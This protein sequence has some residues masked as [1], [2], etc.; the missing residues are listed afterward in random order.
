MLQPERVR[1]PL[2][3]APLRAQHTQYTAHM[4]HTHGISDDVWAHTLHIHDAA[5]AAGT[6]TNYELAVAHFTEW[7]CAE[8]LR[9]DTDTAITE[10][11]LCA[12]AASL[13]GSYSGGTARTKLAG[14]RYWH[15]KR[16]LPWNG[17]ARLKRIL[18]GV[19]ICA[20]P[21]THR[22][23]RPPVTEAMID[24]ALQHLDPIRPFDVCVAAAML[25]AFW[26]QLRLG[27]ILSPTRAYDFGARPAGKGVRLRADA[28]GKLHQL[29]SAIWLPRTKVDRHGAWIWLARHHNDPSYALAEHMRVNAIG[30]DDPLFAYKHDTSHELIALTRNAFLNRLNEIWATAGM[31]RVTGHCFRIGGTTALLRAGVAPEVVK[32]AG[33]WR[34]DSFLR[35]WRAVDSIIS[36]HMDLCDVYWSPDVGSAPEF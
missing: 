16:G 28:G 25:V 26:G 9:I 13:A 22:D 20:P 18:K 30:S 6:I 7:T 10:P 14:I 8:R 36:A 33:R 27:E 31:Q 2:S 35:Y 12:Y 34:S 4:Q 24:E 23:E 32:M 11:V 1:A 19:D 29:T 5:L 21:H 15:D 3:G 17:S